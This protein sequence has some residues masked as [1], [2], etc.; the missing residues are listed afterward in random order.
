VINEAN[1]SP[2]KDLDPLITIEPFPVSAKKT[3]YYFFLSYKNE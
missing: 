1:T 2:A 3:P